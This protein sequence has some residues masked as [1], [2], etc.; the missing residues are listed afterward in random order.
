MLKNNNAKTNYVFADIFKFICS[1][2]VLML[3]VSPFKELDDRIGFFFTNVLARIAVPFFFV[4]TG[5]F[6]FKRFNKNNIDFVKLRKT[7]IKT[8]SLYFLWVILYLPIELRGFIES[9]DLSKDI[10]EY[11]FS[12]FLGKGYYQFWYLRALFVALIVIWLLMYFKVPFKK[13][14]ILSSVLFFI[15]LFETSYKKFLGVFDFIPDTFF[16]RLDDFYKIIGTTRNGCCFAFL[17]V[18]IGILIAWYPIKFKKSVSA[19]LC[20]VS[21][22]LMTFEAFFEEHFELQTRNDKYLLLPFVIYFLFNAVISVKSKNA[23]IGLTFRKL[24]MW[25]Y[26]L[27]FLIYK[28]FVKIGNNVFDIKFKSYVLFALVLITTIL[29]SI[30]LN[31]LSQLKNFKWLNKLI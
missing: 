1:L 14:F 12:I 26:F 19:I 30:I 13:I 8:I 23:S 28:V 11:L 7:I 24:S 25:I 22:V 2:L 17:F 21:F 31:K 29:C 6:L 15:G 18:M 4:C 20:I 3:H 16:E 9:D 10:K 27:H 5:Y